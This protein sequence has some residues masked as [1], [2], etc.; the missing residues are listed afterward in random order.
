MVP[1]REQ[2]K[3]DCKKN[4]NPQSHTNNEEKNSRSSEEGGKV[5]KKK[6][7][8]AYDTAELSDDQPNEKK[9]T[10]DVDQEKEDVPL[11][12]LVDPKTKKDQ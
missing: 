7:E 1:S 3:N 4:N 10:Y 9:K 8:I 11:T 6:E 12:V 5:S 2:I